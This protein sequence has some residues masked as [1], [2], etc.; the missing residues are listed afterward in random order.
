M[1]EAVFWMLISLLDWDE[2]GD[3]DAVVAPVIEELSKRPVEDIRKFDEIL[4]SKLYAL[5]TKAHAQNIGEYAYVEDEYFSVDW[6][7][8]ARCVVVANGKDLYEAVLQNPTSFPKD[9]EFESLL[10][11]AGEAY[12]L[13]TGEDYDH[14]TQLS[15]ETYSNKGGWN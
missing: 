13:R 2:S 1:T 15:W 9:M 11:I 3:D 10:Y 12:A 7:L 4:A 5:D 8:Y 6:F 14:A